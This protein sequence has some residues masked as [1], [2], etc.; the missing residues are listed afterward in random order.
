VP[1][2]FIPSDDQRIAVRVMAACGIAQDNICRAVINKG[3]GRK[4]DL[5]TLRKEFR[6]ELDSASEVC[7]GM[8]AQSLFQKATGDGSQSVTAAIFWLK[9]R[10]GWRDQPSVAPDIDELEQQ[11]RATIARALS[12]DHGSDTAVH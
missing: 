5:V 10:A 8:V 12:E 3:T 11:V 9:A 6:N 2:K 1:A 4:I 7:N